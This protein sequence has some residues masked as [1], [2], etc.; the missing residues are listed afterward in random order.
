MSE[1]LFAE[2]PPIST[3][4]WEQAISPKSV[5]HTEDGI[6]VAPFFRRDSATGWIAPLA[7]RGWKIRCDIANP[8]VPSAHRR[9]LEMIARQADAICFRGTS[10]GSAAELATLL[11]GL[12]LDRVS[13][14]FSR[15]R[16]P[17]EM[18]SL[19]A[20]HKGCEAWS[21]SLEFDP[22][23][24]LAE[25]GL[26]R[27]AKPALFDEFAR[28]YRAVR[29]ALPR[30][31]PVSIRAA[32]FHETGATAVQELGLTLAA[33]AE[34]CAALR[35]RGIAVDDF[36]RGAA[37]CFSIG[38]NYFFEISKLRAARKVWAQMIGAFDSK[39]SSH[40]VWIHARTSSWNR[41]VYDPHV[42]L[43]RGTTEAMAAI[44]GGC[45]SLT[46]EP[47]DEIYKLPDAFS[48]RL[49]IGTQLVLREEAHLGGVADPAA[50]SWYIDWLTGE[51]ERRAWELFQQIEA[52]GGFVVA[53]ESGWIQKQ[54]ESMRTARNHDIATRQRIFTGTSRHPNPVERMAAMPIV[55]DDVEESD[56]I[57]IQVTPL[58]PENGPAPFT[59]IRL[60]TDRYAARTGTAPKVL[61][62]LM[63]DPKMSR[64][65]AAFVADFFGCAGFP[66]EE[67]SDPAAASIVVLCSSD[68]EYA[69][70]APALCR[71]LRD[72]GNPVPVVI[73]GY[74]KDRVDALRAAGVDSFIHVKTNAVEVLTEW[75]EKLGV[76]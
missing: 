14:H 50:G 38:S 7:P 42:N 76:R 36:A 52:E 31:I 46:V 6:D 48:H 35:E 15:M 13:L 71:R 47:F 45:D 20:A 33:G 75:Q 9:A 39:A 18:L 60:A 69:T 73:A 62:V 12:P 5:W 51:V 55:R 26:S 4:Q 64:L 70:L 29:L 1:S 65:R 23:A 24:G 44:A 3:E 53:L 67:G 19:L 63:G 58:L 32:T 34:Y 72:E 57:A 61:L 74:P 11:E 25:T 28:F 30:F 49:A 68:A 66:V 54:V 22:L 43:L 41:S 56:G 10:I 8:D 40:S 2:F 27:V 37:I 59:V 17:A 21:G 16:R